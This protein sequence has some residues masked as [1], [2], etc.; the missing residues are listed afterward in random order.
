MKKPEQFLL[1]SLAVG[2]ILSVSFVIAQ[3]PPSNAPSNTVTGYVQQNL[4][5]PVKDLSKATIVID[6]RQVVIDGI[7]NFKGVDGK[8]LETPEIIS[9]PR[10][11]TDKLILAARAVGQTTVSITEEGSSMIYTVKVI[12]R[13]PPP[14]ERSTASRTIEETLQRL[15]GIPTVKV[16]VLD[17]ASEFLNTEQMNQLTQ[18]NVNQPSSTQNSASSSTAATSSSSSA[19]NSASI[20]ASL[21]SFQPTI[22]LEGE[23][24]DDLDKR[25]ALA[26]A[27][28]FS[29]NVL[30]FLQV[31]N[32]LQVRIKIQVVAVTLDDSSTI[33]LEY[34]GSDDS[35]QGYRTEFGLNTIPRK[36]MDFHYPFFHV[37][38]SGGGPDL[39]V[40]L[41]LI[42]NNSKIK[43]LQEPTITVLNGQSGYFRVGGQFPINRRTI[44]ASGA[45]TITTEYRPFGISL[46]VTPLAPMSNYVP[47]NVD[48]IGDDDLVLGVPENGIPLANQTPGLS[49]IVNP[50]IDKNGIIK[51]YVRPSISSLDFTRVDEDPLNH[52]DPLINERMVETRVAMKDGESLIIGGLFDEDFRESMQSVPFIEKVPVLGELFKNRTKSKERTELVFV[53]TPNVV[54]RKQMEEGDQ[55][56]TRLSE[57]NQYMKGHKIAI[58]E[59]KPTRISASEITPRAEEK[60][61]EKIIAPIAPEANIVA[62]VEETIEPVALPEPQPSVQ[63]D[64]TSPVESVA[65]A[66]EPPVEQPV[67][68]EP[69]EETPVSEGAEFIPINSFTP[70]DAFSVGEQPRQPIEQI[71]P[72]TPED[73]S[74][75][76]EP[77]QEI[78][79]P[80][81]Q[82]TP[83]ST[84][85]TPTTETTTPAE[86]SEENAPVSSET[87]TSTEPSL[88]MPQDLSISLP[89]PNAVPA[90]EEQP[91]APQPVN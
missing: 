88:M 78:P 31:A 81:P 25:R 67:A 23:V 19:Q 5:I 50:S 69:T 56:P 33:G 79:V 85:E 24:P 43:V 13:D 37:A 20:Q 63:T 84:E 49:N 32:P 28:S 38:R 80:P 70:V 61:A 1:A 11:I 46:L 87:S 21:P 39:T 91:P 53:L 7:W 65:P 22:I 73:S 41:N 64:P 66:A 35:V 9:Q 15:I 89:A 30:E 2:L 72:G 29:N 74:A 26:M 48:R 27:K 8:V 90:G 18:A 36:L 68:T 86:A 12:S 17:A 44:D 40:F 62:P 83:P 75:M 6:N 60:P 10:T 71:Q 54:G 3:Q 77:I 57:F 45:I 4:I 55:F 58:A 16:S 59:P 34:Q 47:G 52:P 76:V 51:L 42:K 82:E 14:R